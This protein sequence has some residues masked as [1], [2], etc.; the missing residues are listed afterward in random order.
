MDCH[1]TGHFRAF[2]GT[3]WYRFQRFRAPLCR[4][5][6]LLCH[7]GKHRLTDLRRTRGAFRPRTF[8]YPTL[9]NA[10]LVEVRRG[11]VPALPDGEL[12]PARR[13][14]AGGSYYHFPLR[15]ALSFPVKRG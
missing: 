10:A 7:G 9:E 6:L 11:G 8:R 13:P 2:F 14:F 4:I 12:A 3:F 5:S 1:P 15:I